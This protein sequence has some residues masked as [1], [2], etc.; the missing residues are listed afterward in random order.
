MPDQSAKAIQAGAALVDI[1]PADGLAMSGFAARVTPATGMHD[2][3]TVRAVVVNDTAIVCADVIG[4]HEDSCRRIRERSPNSN[5]IV[6]A[7]HTHGGPNTMPGRLGGGCDDRYLSR[8]EDACVEAIETAC[9]NRCPAFL[10]SGCGTDPNVA[11]NRRHSGGVVD[12]N[13]P[14]LGIR[15]EGGEWIAV[16]ASYACHPVVLGADNTLWT[17]DYP[18]IVRR[19]LEAAYAGALGIF[20]LGCAGDANTGHSASASFNAAPSETRTFEEAE[21]IGL[22]VSACALQANLEKISNTM[23]RSTSG[24]VHLDFERREQASSQELAKEWEQQSAAEPSRTALLN[25]WIDWAKTVANSP[26]EPWRARVVVLNWGGIPIVALPGEIFAET[27]LAIRK[28][29][30][31]DSAF[32]VCFSNG[33]PGYISPK[34]EYQY[35]GYEVDEAHRYYGMGASFAPG[36]AE[37]LLTL[38][39]S[40]CKQIGVTE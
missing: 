31:S 28:E 21:R 29:V 27:A 40:L 34:S 30:A 14:V 16:I 20:L 9:S 8:L 33:C 3:L 2:P 23:V 17:A 36:S 35:G 6:S 19:E 1:T 18:G 5:V 38:T 22:K 24:E 12:P 26:L 39:S 4:L 10:Y 37:R 25:T 32:V 7:L 11:K 13:L 15:K